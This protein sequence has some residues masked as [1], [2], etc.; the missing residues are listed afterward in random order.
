VTGVQTC[1]LPIC[2]RRFPDQR[3]FAS[4]MET[5]GFSRV[6]F[7]NFTAGVAALHQGWA[8]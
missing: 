6:T 3:T 8:I 7:T 5:A 4:M 1:A 2:I